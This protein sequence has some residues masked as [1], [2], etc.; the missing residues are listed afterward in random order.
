V[1]ALR[2]ATD[3][4]LRLLAPVIPFATEEV[5]RWTHD[6]SIHTAAWPTVAELNNPDAPRGLLPAVSAALIGIRR[7]KTDAKASQKTEV[8]SATLVGP[9]LLAEAA[10]DL[11]GVGRITKLTILEADEVAVTDIVLAEATVE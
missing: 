10:D 5:W 4:L 2:L 1:T 6:G 7:A 8:L 11:R 9:A 3:V